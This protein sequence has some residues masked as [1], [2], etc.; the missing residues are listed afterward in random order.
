MMNDVSQL[1]NYI[2]SKDMSNSILTG[3]RLDDK[4]TSFSVF[5]H[6]YA[7]NEGTIE[8]AHASGTTGNI[9]ALAF[10]M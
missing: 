4:I 1:T 6:G 10:Q 2:N 7:S 3:A 9:S 5:S 8:F